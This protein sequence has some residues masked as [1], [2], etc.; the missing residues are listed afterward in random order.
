M[1]LAKPTPRLPARPES[2]DALAPSKATLEPGATPTLSSTYGCEKLTGAAHADPHSAHAPATTI[3]RHAFMQSPPLSPRTPSLLLPVFLF[4]FLLGHPL[5]ARELGAFVEVDQAHPL[6][7]APHLADLL[8]LR[9]DEH[10]AGG[11]QHDLVLVAHQHRA[12]DLAVPLARLDRDHALSAAAVARVFG[13]RRALAEAFLG[14]GQHG[15]G[16]A[17]GDQHRDDAPAF[18]DLHAAHPARLAPHRPHVG[19]LE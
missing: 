8:D 2:S 1:K 18:A 14:R 3:D 12:D 16:L 17:V 15:L 4:L 19:L 13:D 9:A 5:H 7:R 10:A 6:R 11:D